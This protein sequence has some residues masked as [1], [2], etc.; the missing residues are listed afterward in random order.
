MDS[1]RHD[2]V[3]CTTKRKGSY[4]KVLLKDN[5]YPVVGV[6]RKIKA[7]KKNYPF[8]NP[9]SLVLQNGDGRGTKLVQ[10]AEVRGREGDKKNLSG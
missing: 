6:E 1:K 4:L 8:R 7:K 10:L 2:L 5:T 3:H 9:N